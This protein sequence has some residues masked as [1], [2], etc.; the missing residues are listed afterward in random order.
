MIKLSE[1]SK[2]PIKRKNTDNLSIFY[3]VENRNVTYPRLEFKKDKILI[4]LP[5]D[6]K[7]EKDILTKKHSWITKKQ[8]IIDKSIKNLE[9]DYHSHFMVLGEPSQMKHFTESRL[10]EILK[11]KLN[12][13]SEVYSKSLKVKIN[14]M[15]IRK[16]KTKWASC[17]EKRNLS[18]NLKLV[19]LPENL[20]RYVVYHEM[21]HIREKKHNRNFWMYIKKEFPNYKKMENLLLGF[22]FYLDKHD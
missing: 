5:K 10:K 20:I 3:E 15:S 9:S 1:F 4:V 14:G 6:V 17:S 12:E 8:R 2:N 16:Q 22:W 13:F 7:N 11:E 18:F 19:H 21:V